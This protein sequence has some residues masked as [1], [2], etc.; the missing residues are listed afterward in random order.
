MIH[1]TEP[2]RW[3]RIY[4]SGPIAIAEQVCREE[5]QSG[6]CVTIE[7]T[8]FIYTGGEELGFVI[9]LINYPRFPSEQSVIT[10]RAKSIAMKLMER[11]CQ[12]SSLVMTPDC[13]DWYSILDNR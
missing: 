10:D 11:L 8:K 7:P 4:M 13:T 3:A 6:L 5:C 12:H 1:K 9:G 2:T